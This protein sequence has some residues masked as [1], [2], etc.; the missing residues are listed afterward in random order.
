MRAI[1]VGPP[2]ITL[3][4]VPPSA[5]STISFAS[6]SAA[7]KFVPWPDFNCMDVEQSM[8]SAMSFLPEVPNCFCFQTY[9]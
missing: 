9:S 8:M 7:S 6:A 2:R 3:N 5:F 4:A 1:G